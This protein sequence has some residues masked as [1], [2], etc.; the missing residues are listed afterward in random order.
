M[1]KT[2]KQPSKKPMKTANEIAVVCL[3]SMSFALGA[4]ISPALQGLKKP[5]PLP[6]PPVTID[7]EL[8]T[9]LIWRVEEPIQKIEL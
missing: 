5:A 9:P 1:N 3:C 6:K 4:L 2:R 7:P 8:F